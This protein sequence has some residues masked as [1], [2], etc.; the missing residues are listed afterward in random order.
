MK[1]IIPAPSSYFMALIIA[2]IIFSSMAFRNPFLTQNESKNVQL[3]DTIPDTEHQ[4]KYRCGK[5]YSR[6]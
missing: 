2:A 4:Y 1:T 3:A 5:N 6:S